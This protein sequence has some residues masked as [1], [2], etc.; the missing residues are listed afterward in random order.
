MHARGAPDVQTVTADGRPTTPAIDGVLL[1]TPPVHLDH[2]GALYE[3]YA[4][5]SDLWSA[6]IVYSYVFTVRPRQMKGWGMHEHKE[7]RYSL[8]V[9]EDLLLLHDDRPG[10]ATCGVTQAVVLSERGTRQVVIPRG[11][12]HLHVNLTPHEAHLINF[13]TEVYN[14]AAPD[15]LMLPWDTDE[16][17]VDVR[18]YLPRA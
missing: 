1:H 3:L 2:R 5:D 9:G 16:L 6:P 8:V 18:K 14:H 15:R 12:W 4:G 7:D 11:V 13:P 17:D 10:S